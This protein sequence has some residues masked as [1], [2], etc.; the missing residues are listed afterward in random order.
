MTKGLELKLAK[1][2]LEDAEDAGR[3][4]ALV[5]ETMTH[6]SDLAH[7]LATLDLAERD[8][9]SALGDLAAHVRELFRITCRFSA[10]GAIP[11]LEAPVITQ[12]YKIA[13]E[14]VTNSIKHGKARKVSISLADSADKLVLTIQNDGLPFP[15]MRSKTT[16]MGLRIM[17]YRANLIG[18]SLDVRAVGARGGT[19]VTCALPLEARTSVAGPSVGSG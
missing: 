17:N 10:T 11:M 6:A 12:L 14:A 3:I 8:L 4:H 13:Q 7:D 2:H 18:A 19:L 16:G 5:Q 1:Q 15:D 9:P